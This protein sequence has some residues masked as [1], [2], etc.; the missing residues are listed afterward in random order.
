[1]PD[2][3]PSRSGRRSGEPPR[4]SDEAFRELIARRGEE[5]RL[6]AN[7]IVSREGQLTWFTRPLLGEM[8]HQTTELEELLDAYGARNNEKWCHLRATVA[9]AK[10]FAN[11]NY[12]LLHIHH[13]LPAYRLLGDGDEFVHETEKA[14]LFT[15]EVLSKTAERFVAQ[16]LD[17]GL[18]LPDIAGCEEVYEEPLPPG[19]LPHDLTPRK[20]SDAG[21]TVTYI[22]TAFL[23]QAAESEMLHVPQRVTPEKYPECIPASVS[24]ERLRHLQ[25][26]FHN[27]QSMYDT[28]V[29]DTDTERA[30]ADLPVLRGHVSVIFHLLETATAFAHYYERHVMSHPGKKPDPDA[31]LVEGGPLLDVLMT[32]SLTFASKYLVA[33]RDL[34]HEMLR[35]FAKIGEVTVSAPRYRGFHVRPSTLVAKIVRHYGSEVT[36]VVE[37]DTYD[38]A[39]PMDIFRAN[40]KLNRQK[41]TWLTTQVCGLPCLKDPDFAAD[42]PKAVRRV[43]LALAEH[44]KVV[45]YERPIPVEPPVEADADKTPV[46]YILDEV[47]RLQATGMIDIEADIPITFRGDERC[48]HDLQLLAENGYGEDNFGNNIPLPKELSFL[49]R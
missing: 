8:L 35:K 1:M 18:S 38:A 40:E 43:I 12:V 31:A 47:A 26:Q 3:D 22:A 29:S 2:T 42:L 5:A 32:Y 25:H 36:M 9:A 37:G 27:L 17:L 16:S 13:A 45:I 46:Q 49:R 33:G 28:F 21:Q 48:L 41:R 15:G 4:I 23:N 11:V 14:I 44:G 39:S 19:R 30:N 20:D 24:E 34:C 6:L 7:Y 10:L